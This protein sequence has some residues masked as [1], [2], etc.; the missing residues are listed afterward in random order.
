MNE[1]FAAQILPCIKDLGLMDKIDEK[2]NLNGKRSPSVTRWV[3]PGH[4]SAPR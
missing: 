1:A 2:I 3:V 4:V